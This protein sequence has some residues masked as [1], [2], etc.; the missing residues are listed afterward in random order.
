MSDSGTTALPTDGAPVNDADPLKRSFEHCRRIS[1]SRARN[2]HYGMKLVPE[3]KRS[4]MFAVYAW[5]RQADDLADSPGEE[6]QK[7]ERIERFRRET[8]RAVDPNTD[9][10]QLPDA[11]LWPAVRHTVLT[12]GIPA[13]YLHAM[14][15]GQLQD[16]T[17][18]RYKTFDELYGYCYKV[19][20]VVGLTCLQVWGYDGGESTR[21]LAEQRGI[22]FQLTNILRDVMEDARLDRVY[23][24]AEL[25][26]L[27]ELNPSM[28]TL[29]PQG[30]S[31]K[32]IAKLADRAAEYYDRSAPLDAMVHRDGRP[33][34]WA[35]TT[36]YRA[37]LAKIQRDPAVVLSG[38]RVR[39]S[40]PRKGWIALRASIK[41]LSG[42][43]R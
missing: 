33:C 26:D 41:G 27:F 29:G 22:A 7:A 5:M 43:G 8:L 17:Q 15:D 18:R 31:V 42:G 38:R 20:S 23:M 32:G 6:R 40:A 30:E 25:F 4:A 1:G 11:P 37:L 35:M 39:L 36:I 19:A 34:L 13:D 21:K 3:P 24:P 9:A 12:Y 10:E 16:M 28:F 14:L 2:F